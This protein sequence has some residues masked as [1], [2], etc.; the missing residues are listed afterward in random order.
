MAG[1]IVTATPSHRDIFQAIDE[2][3]LELGNL[4]DRI[5]HEEIQADG[6]VVGTGLTGRVI[7]TEA[8]V[9]AY[10]RLKERIIGGL[11]TATVLLAVVWWLVKAK[12]A[13]L[14]GVQ[15]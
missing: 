2:L 12:I 7:R 1:E 15:P 3:R 6:S 11:A 9:L 8:K 5:G 10:D 4:S 14:F 13:G